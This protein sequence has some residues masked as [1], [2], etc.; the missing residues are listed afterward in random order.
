[1]TNLHF[2]S[3]VESV[4][5]GNNFFKF[6]FEFRDETWEQIFHNQVFISEIDHN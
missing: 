5:L 3:K 1:M 2:T 6:C 4:I